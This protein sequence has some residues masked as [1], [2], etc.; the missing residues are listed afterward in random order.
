MQLVGQS[1]VRCRAR[2]TR[3]GDARFCPKCGSAVHTACAKPGAGGCRAC[4]AEVARTAPHPTEPGAQEK[5]RG[6]NFILLG[7]LLMMAGVLSGT[8]L[9]VLS[10]TSKL[11]LIV[12]L[13][14]A[15]AALVFVGVLRNRRP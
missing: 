12:G 13:M 1:C 2:I 6:Y 11:V 8:C 3:E 5:D 9:S 10:G 14:T 15:G 4:G 7:V